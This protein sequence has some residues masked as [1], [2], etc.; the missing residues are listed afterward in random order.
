MV[1][2]L[3][4][5]KGTAAIYLA[6]LTLTL[7]AHLPSLGVPWQY[8]DFHHIA[9]NPAVM[10]LA[11]VP[12]F[13]LEPALFSSRVIAE[14]MYRPLLM[15]SHALTYALFGD[16][17]LGA[18]LVNLM[19]H[20]LNTALALSLLRRWTGRD[21][22]AL[23]G[24]LFWSLFAVQAETVAYASA[25]S[26]LLGSGFMLAAV[27]LTDDGMGRWKQAGLAALFFI[28][29][30]LAKEIAFALPLLILAR[31]LTLGRARGMALARRWPVYAL[32]FA[33]M[34]AYLAARAVLF[35]SALG[36]PYMSR[37]TYLLTQAKVFFLYI[38]WTLFPLNLTPAPA[39]ATAPGLFSPL[40]LTG[41]LGVIA[42]LVFALA[43]RVRAPRFSFGVAWFAIGLAP[44]STLAPLYLIASVERIYLPLLGLVLIGA[45]AFE[46]VFRDAPGKRK[47]AA[48]LG[49]SVIALNAALGLHVQHVWRSTISL[50]R[51]MVRMAPQKSQPWVWLGIM[52]MY[53]NRLA[54]ARKHMLKAM[55]QD[56]DD[57]LAQ[58]SYGKLLLLSRSKGAA[59]EVF[60]SVL[61]DPNS[62]PS[63]KINAM[64]RLAAFDMDEGK[65]KE[66]EQRAR[67]VLQNQPENYEAFMILGLVAQQSGDLP[68]AKNYYRSALK[69][70]PDYPE[71]E[72]KLGGIAMQ[73]GDPATARRLFSNVISRG[74]PM[75]EAY[76]NLGLLD[77]SE[78]RLDEAK[79]LFAQAISIDPNDPRGYYGM[80]LFYAGRAEWDEAQQN[81]EPAVVKNPDFIDARSALANVYMDRVAAG[82][83]AGKDREWWLARAAD[84]LKWLAARGM[85]KEA[86]EKWERLAGRK[87]P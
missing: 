46:S 58:E 79:E 33:L 78:G 75:P 73:E 51:Q 87:L 39:V 42:L 65:L 22:V 55:R 27:R 25:R 36:E 47:I 57:P 53:D 49:A 83:L 38:G 12:R 64:I 48:V 72:I 34:P 61:R 59:R 54:A 68:A 2:S 69:I 8:D 45:A 40:A 80:G 60:E 11:N 41:A 71:V 9:E 13:F 66:A 19:L 20:L 77:L 24:T 16:N 43:L 84:Q 37:F 74:K 70:M 52:E 32:T 17:P 82:N 5:R 62:N 6:A 85:G 18:H 7:I 28:L 86:V 10:R 30:L 4:T 26:T 21:A 35:S 29:A 31:D 44:T 81:L 3:K 1:E 56:P 76:V 23:M 63:S 67:I 15:T 14:G 50:T